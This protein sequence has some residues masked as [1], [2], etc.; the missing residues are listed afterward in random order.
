MS[1]AQEKCAA[2]ED[3]DEDTFVRFN[4]FLYTGDYSVPRPEILLTSED[5]AS[6]DELNRTGETSST[7]EQPPEPSTVNDE[8]PAPVED[9]SWSSWGAMA[10]TSKK[11]S[12]KVSHANHWREEL[13]VVS[14]PAAAESACGYCGTT[15]TKHES[16][17]DRLWSAFK[18]E[19]Y[20][21]QRKSWEPCQNKE[22]CE[23]Y[24]GVF[25]CH[26]HLY[27]LSDRYGIEP[28]QQLTLQKLRLT[29]SRFTFFKERV[30]DVV[31]LVKYTYKHTMGHDEGIDKLR[32]LV[33]DYV[34]CHLE[35]VAKDEDFKDMLQEPG[36]LAKDL[37][38]K[39]LQRLD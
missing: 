25:L 13:E 35:M 23:S 34:V 17:K 39:T 10:K 4:E 3:V 29:L 8:E 16:K 18:E 5:I 21:K 31:E 32:S 28:L 6:E 14:E 20:V 1:E 26:A 33:M 19:S 11:K 22:A 37:I 24:A 7:I 2:I 30:P 27:V 9:V 12:K 36:A 38:L 15:Q